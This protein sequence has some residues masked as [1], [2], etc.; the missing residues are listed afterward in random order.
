MTTV[1]ASTHSLWTIFCVQMSKAE[2]CYNRA[3]KSL[4]DG[5]APFHMRILSFSPTLPHVMQSSFLVSCAMLSLHSVSL[6]MHLGLL[7]TEE[8][9]R[10]EV[11]SDWR[12]GCS[13][14]STT[15]DLRSA[16]KQ[17]PLHKSDVN[18]AVVTLRNPICGK[19]EH[20]TVC[21]LPF[22]VWS[23]HHWELIKP[24][25]ASWGLTTHPRS[26]ENPTF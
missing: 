12:G 5:P 10:G 22:G 8:R 16:Y 2:I 19:A 26:F 1:P 21:T 4:L 18:K 13:L 6:H 14:K 11:H 23:N 20:F 17:L 15:L 25:W 24:C 9:L 3:E 7:K